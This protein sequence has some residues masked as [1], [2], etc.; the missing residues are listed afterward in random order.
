MSF[1]SRWLDMA[2]H[3]QLVK[4]LEQ[5]NTET[6]HVSMATQHLF[7]L[8]KNRASQNVS[9]ETR[10]SKLTTH[11]NMSSFDERPDAHFDS[12]APRTPKTYPIET[13]NILGTMFQPHPPISHV[14]PC[15]PHPWCFRPF[16]TFPLFIWLS[17]NYFFKTINESNGIGF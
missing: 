13:C 15:N 12:Q 1:F 9:L 16:S 4:A 2:F 6:C 8:I 14:P 11:W 7:W 17:S 5:I 3:T 10:T